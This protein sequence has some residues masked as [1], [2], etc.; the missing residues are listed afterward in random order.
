MEKK[1][2]L[3]LRI[4]D[5]ILWSVTIV[6]II[7]IGYVIWY[8]QVHE[9]N[10]LSWFKFWKYLMTILFL[11]SIFVV[12]WLI[13]GGCM[14]LRKLLRSLKEEVVDET[15]DGFVRKNK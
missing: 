1:K 9:V 5:L 6:L 7:T 3:T 11:I 2:S 12:V 8:N 10:P 4:I 13:I 14:D 15:D